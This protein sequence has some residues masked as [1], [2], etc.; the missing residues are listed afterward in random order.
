MYTDNLIMLDDRDKD[1]SPQTVSKLVIDG[2]YILKKKKNA[3]GSRAWDQFRVVLN[4]LNDE[5]VFGVALKDFA[6]SF[7]YRVGCI[8]WLCTGF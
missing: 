5:E 7:I 8:S 2:D 3:K 6:Q 4:P 1:I